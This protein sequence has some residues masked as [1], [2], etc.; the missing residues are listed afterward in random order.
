MS[1]YNKN[2][3][4]RGLA[5]FLVVLL[6]L[7]AAVG[8][9]AYFS[10]WFTDWDKFKPNE[11]EYTQEDIEGSSG[12]TVR[13]DLTYETL[14]QLNGKLDWPCNVVTFKD[15]DGAAYH[16]YIVRN[17]TDNNFS[18]D[19]RSEAPVTK[20]L[21]FT[22]TAENELTYTTGAKDSAESLTVESLSY[23]EESFTA[24]QFLLIFEK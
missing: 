7:M 12:W 17:S 3:G 6:V 20:T 14:T 22:V 4:L 2:K 23:G 19:I 1:S 13:D 11:K 10:D 15:G 18:V 8:V 9:V 24:E 21:C 16:L 5:V